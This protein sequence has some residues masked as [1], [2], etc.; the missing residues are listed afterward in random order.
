MRRQLGLLCLV[1]FF[2]LLAAANAQTPSSST[3]GASFDGTYRFVSSAKVNAT[4][5]T[6]GGHLGQCPERA[7]GPLTVVR[8]RARY[9]SATG[10][11]LKGTVGPQGELAMRLLA[12]P[13]SNGY[14][15]IELIVSGSI[16]GTGTIRAR[17]KGNSCS[18]D[19]VWQK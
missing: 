12:L 2:G 16:D 9:T 10:R 7:A 11:Q 3:A 6:R 17:Q 19:F 13:G 14:R 18:Y 1:G 15:P 8:G 5:V 4:F